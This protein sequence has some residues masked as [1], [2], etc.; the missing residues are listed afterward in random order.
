MAVVARVSAYSDREFQGTVSAIN[1]AIDP[2]SR[3]FVLEARFPNSDNALRPGMFATAR[4]ILGGG[5][6]AVFVP[7]KSIVRDK[8]TDSNLVYIADGGQ[9][10]MRVVLVG[11]ADGDSVRIQS[12]LSGNES[13]ITNNQS[14]L[15]D[16]AAIQPK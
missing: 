3:V 14:Q 7:R 11:E 6:S 8:T 5:E 10:R 2:N 4:I 12:G 9:A 16:G 13:V 15:F 1:P